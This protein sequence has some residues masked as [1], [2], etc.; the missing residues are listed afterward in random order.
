MLA[1]AASSIGLSEPDV[2]VRFECMREKQIHLASTLI[3]SDECSLPNSSPPRVYNMA[4]IL[5]WLAT[6]V[7][8]ETVMS[9]CV[10]AAGHKAI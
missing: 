6:I 1:A 4:L 3:V 7:P 8:P 9:G 5:Q 10:E 2:S